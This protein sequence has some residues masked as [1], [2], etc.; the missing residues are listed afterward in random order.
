MPLLSKEIPPC[1]SILP[2][3]R[4]LIFLPKFCLPAYSTAYNSRLTNLLI[5][6]YIGTCVSAYSTGYRDA[7]IPTMY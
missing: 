1:L 4:V 5:P 2:A 6:S 7:F 3:I